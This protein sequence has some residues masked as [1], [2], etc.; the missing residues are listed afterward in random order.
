MSR[1]LFCFT[2]TSIIKSSV[3]TRSEVKL[4][5]LF[6]AIVLDKY[7]L[8]TSRSGQHYPGEAVYVAMIS[9]LGI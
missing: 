7:E 6:L 8:P 4:C 1:Q 2:W 5:A 3:L 9:D